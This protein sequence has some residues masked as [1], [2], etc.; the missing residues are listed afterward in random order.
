M[1]QGWYEW[2]HPLL[3]EKQT[4]VP[5]MSCYP[6]L[7]QGGSLGE[8]PVVL[9]AQV[10]PTPHNGPYPSPP[11]RSAAVLV[12]DAVLVPPFLWEA[13]WTHIPLPPTL[14]NSF[15]SSLS[16]LLI[17]TQNKLHGLEFTQVY[18]KNISLV[19]ASEL[20]MSNKLQET[21][22]W[23]VTWWVRIAGG[24]GQNADIKSV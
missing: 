2:V 19:Q 17:R 7:Y 24:N 18:I 11:S 1:E 5:A 13:L 15:I 23:V 3:S 9:G 22:Q 21:S 12:P 8:P 16:L 10:A 20:L 4:Q 14:A 6:E